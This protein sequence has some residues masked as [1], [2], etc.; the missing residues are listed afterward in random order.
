MDIALTEFARARLFPRGGRRNAIQDVT[1]SEFE[2]Y[3]NEHPPLMVQAATG[4]PPDV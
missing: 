3:L 1:A 2:R 4:L